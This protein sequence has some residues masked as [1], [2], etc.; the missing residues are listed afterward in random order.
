MKNLFLIF[1]LSLASF[2]TN[3]E[4]M[5]SIFKTKGLSGTFVVYD[6]KR[7]KYDYYDLNRAN[8]R[9][10]PASTFKIFNTLIGLENGVVKN[11]DEVFYY[12]DGSKVF[13]D[14]WAMDS[15]LRYAI[16]VSQVPAY[17]KL[18]REIG[19]DKMQEGI[20]R[21]NYGNKNIGNEIDKFWLEGPLKINAMEQVKLLNLL[22]QSKLAF[23]LQ[24]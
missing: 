14:S 22:A 20:N 5:R 19:K 8:E 7:D 12:Y 3:N 10:Y 13:L 23:K 21:L 15:S 4:V 16:K 18:A 24:N 6:L 11:V 17:K 1:I 9:F 2:A